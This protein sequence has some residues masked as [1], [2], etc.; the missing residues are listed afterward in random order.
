LTLNQS[1]RT[2]SVFGKHVSAFDGALSLVLVHGSIPSCGVLRQKGEPRPSPS[3][4]F[5]HSADTYRAK[6]KSAA[7]DGFASMTLPLFYDTGI[8]ADVAVREREQKN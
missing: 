5:L 4:W 7:F 6:A 1:L 2:D 3:A 8:D